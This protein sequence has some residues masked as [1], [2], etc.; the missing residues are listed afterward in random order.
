MVEGFDAGA[1]DYLIKPVAKRDLLARID[2]HL[3]LAELTGSLERKVLER[4]RELEEA[5][6]QL[7]AA[8]RETA[9]AMAE[10][11]VLEERNRIAFEIH[12]TVGHTL[13]AC[14]AQMEAAKMLM[15]RGLADQAIPK[16][17]TAREL[18]SK[19]LSELRES[20]RMLKQE[21]SHENLSVMLLKL[22][23]DTEKA[24]G[25]RI[26]ADIA[27]LPALGSMQ[28]RTILPC[29]AGRLDE[30]NS[31]RREPNVHLYLGTRGRHAVVPAGQRRRSDPGG[32]GFLLRPVGDGGKCPPFGRQT[33][34]GSGGGTGRPALHRYPAG[35]AGAEPLRGGSG[36]PKT[37]RVKR[38]SLHPQMN[39]V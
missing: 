31:P 39:D 14:I 38:P 8:M 24:A 23:R 4:T 25:V 7:Q 12:N 9:Q 16:L 34:A 17:D 35:L 5:G 27:P 29:P 19:G 21:C 20:V 6:R 33:D 37:K 1:N 13:T 32:S 10:A 3:Q 26:D 22:I 18:V 28:K 2:M 15:S 30:R 36:Q 11:S